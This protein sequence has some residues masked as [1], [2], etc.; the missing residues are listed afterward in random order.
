M[1]NNFDKKFKIL[2]RCIL[3]LTIIAVG[4]VFVVGRDFFY[5][6]LLGVMLSYLL[7]PL[8]KFFEPKIGHSGVS[9]LLS[10]FVSV[11][12]TVGFI[13]FFYSQFS[14]F[15]DE[16]PHFQEQAVS[17]LAAVQNYISEK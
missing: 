11:I 4:T 1:K 13:F 14:I 7:Y 9:I 12:V 10:I 6:V 5:P 2:Q 8:A 17:N 16:F 15:L 3:I